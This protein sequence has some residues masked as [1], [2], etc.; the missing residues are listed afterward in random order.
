[1]NKLTKEQSDWLIE[2]FNFAHND[3]MLKPAEGMFHI[4][5]CRNI[6]KQCTDKEF[7]RKEIGGFSINYYPFDH[8]VTIKSGGHCYDLSI[9]LFK[10][11][12]QHYQE[13]AEYLND[14]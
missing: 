7:P 9:D 11:L 5:D 1:M 8:I 10:Q 12:A 2:Q 3:L 6:I 13:I 14:K 4:M